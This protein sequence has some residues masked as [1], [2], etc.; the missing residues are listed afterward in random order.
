MKRLLFLI[1]LTSSFFNVF[2]MEI[3]V[4]VASINN[5]KLSGITVYAYNG[6]TTINA[7]TNSS[8]IAT[9]QVSSIVNLELWAADLNRRFGIAVHKVN[10]SRAVYRLIMPRF[11]QNKAETASMLDGILKVYGAYSDFKEIKDLASK[12]R[13]AGTGMLG[14][15]GVFSISPIPIKDGNGVVGF[16]V[17]GSLARPL[18]NFG[19]CASGLS[20]CEYRMGAI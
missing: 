14:I 7:V 20:G 12:F 10:S 5:Q 18:Y 17:S 3:T 9:L 1:L 2:A 19:N 13:S 15:P 4:E 6:K 11:P 8:G 16:Q